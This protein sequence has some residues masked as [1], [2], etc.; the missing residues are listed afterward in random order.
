MSCETH[1][2]HLYLRPLR[3]VRLRPFWQTHSWKPLTYSHK[4]LPT[5]NQ[6]TPHSPSCL[7]PPLLESSQ[8]WLPQPPKVVHSISEHFPMVRCP[9]WSH[10]FHEFNKSLL[11][12]HNEKTLLR[13][14][15]GRALWK[16]DDS[17]S[18]L[19]YYQ[20]QVGRGVFA[21]WNLLTS[22]SQACI[23]RVFFIQQQ[24]K[25]VSPIPWSW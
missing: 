11:N 17:N 22:P 4:T 23:L 14:R 1:V 21:K 13:N 24:R 7:T 10:N 18:P 25:W 6:T 16:T 2:E 12:T 20:P 3:D 5:L 9:P 19:S 15:P 8:H